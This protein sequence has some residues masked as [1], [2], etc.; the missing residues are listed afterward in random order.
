MGKLKY[1]LTSG[2]ASVA[3]ALGVAFPVAAQS[4]T[5]TCV[6]G[7]VGLNLCPNVN[8]DNSRTRSTTLGAGSAIVRNSVLQA[9]SVSAKTTQ[10]NLSGATTGVGV[11]GAGTGLG[12]GVLGSGTGVGAGGAGTGTATNNQGNWSSTTATGTQTNNVSVN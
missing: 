10:L 7:L 6:N 11:G 3:V 4:Q 5:T 1:V 2:A 12:V 9:Q 8:V